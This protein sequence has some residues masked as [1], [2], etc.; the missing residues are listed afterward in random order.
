MSTH[1]HS[2]CIV[3]LHTLIH[4]KQLLLQI[5]AQDIQNLDILF[6]DFIA[7]KH[8]AYASVFLLLGQKL[9]KNKHQTGARSYFIGETTI[10]ICHVLKNVETVREQLS[11]YKFISIKRDK[12]N[13]RKR[14]INSYDL[15]RIPKFEPTNSNAQLQNN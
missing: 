7:N 6:F 8:T 11:T 12:L 15:F 2:T 4:R 5:I 10:L 1:K 3:V 13:K 9:H 14:V